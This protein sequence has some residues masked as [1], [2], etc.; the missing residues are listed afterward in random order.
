M[1]GSDLENLP[2]HRLCGLVHRI[3]GN[4]GA[5][6]RKGAGAPV[7]LIG[8]ACDH[9]DIAH[10]DPNLVGNDLRE[11]GRVALPLASYAGRDAYFAVGLYLDLGALVRSDAGTFDI[12]SNTDPGV[13]A[14]RPQPRLL[15]IDEFAV[16]DEIERLV[17]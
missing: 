9:I 13:A 16:A 8:I 7:E 14:L 4:D 11:A 3:S 12:A 1:F 10:F 5:A 15:F 2:S 17:E 6:A